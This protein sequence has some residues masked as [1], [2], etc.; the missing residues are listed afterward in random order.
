MRQNAREHLGFATGPHHCLGRHLA[1]L[2]MR[3][4]LDFILTNTKNLQ[5]ASAGDEPRGHEF[6][7]PARLCLKWDR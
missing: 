4:A 3:L 6:R 1:Q 2:Q 5:L 7:Q